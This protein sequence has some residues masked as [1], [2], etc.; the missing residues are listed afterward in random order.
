M[1]NLVSLLYH[2]RIIQIRSFNF[3]FV[4]VD[5]N[6]MESGNSEQGATVAPL[7]KCGKRNKQEEIIDKIENVVERFEICVQ[8]A[9]DAIKKDEVGG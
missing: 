2:G 8:L 9:G 5:K 7:A 6:M 4:I 3:F 1:L